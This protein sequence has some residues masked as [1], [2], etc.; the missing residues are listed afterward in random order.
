M[1]KHLFLALSVATTFG[2]VS[3]SK[4]DDD[5]IDTEASVRVVHTIPNAGSVNF[6]IDGTQRNSSA[7]GFGE[8]T[9]YFAIDKGKRTAEFK[10]ATG[11]NTLLTTPVD[12][13][14]GNYTLF[15][16]G[17]PGDNTLAAVVVADD[18]QTPAAGKVRVRVAHMS[19][20]APSVNV[21]VNDSLLLSNAAYKS[22]SGFVEI[23]ARTY[24]VKLNNSANGQN[25]YTRENV[26]LEAGKNYTL[27]AQGLTSGAGA[28]TAPLSVSAVAY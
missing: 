26:T 10:S 2:F 9:G 22:V 25:A 7:F 14:S 6:F 16:T 18:L 24:T 11:N 23:P 4:D 5:V 15:A 19:P 17:L 27:T 1:K 20:D 8:S 21:L 13:G 12:F 28:I 3:C